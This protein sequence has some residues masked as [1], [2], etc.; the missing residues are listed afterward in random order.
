MIAEYER[1]PIRIHNSAVML[2]RIFTGFDHLDDSWTWDLEK[3]PNAM[4]TQAAAQFIAQ[5]EGHDCP[6]FHMAL[7]AACQKQLD[8]WR[9]RASEPQEPPHG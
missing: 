8:E 1:H 6:A 9:A 7:I 5:L 3:D 2:V 4:Y